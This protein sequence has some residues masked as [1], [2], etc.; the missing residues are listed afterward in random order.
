VNIV[1]A[2]S[3]GAEI[4]HG[5]DIAEFRREASSL[6]AFV[7]QKDAAF[8]IAHPEFKLTET[9]GSA[10]ESAIQ[11]RAAREPFQYI[12]GRQEFWGLE[13][14]VTPDVL[15]PR[16]ETEILVEAAIGILSQIKDAHVC[17]V[18]VGSGCIAVSIAHSLP[19]TTA[20]VTDISPAAI[21]VATRNAKR[22]DVDA[23]IDF[24]EADVFEGVTGSFDMI[25]SNPP[26]IPDE[27][28]EAL[29]TEVRD[30]EP[31]RALSGGRDG[32]DV[33]SRIV[34]EAP[35][36]LKPGGSLLMEIG[37]DQAARVKELF[38]KDLWPGL[39]FLPDLQGIPRIARAR[40]R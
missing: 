28:I 7:L 4:L 13:F 11:R 14:E 39:E 3:S 31:R 30:F 34:A 27:Q 22:H 20:V 10:F 32:T 33:I 9:Q 25:V 19:A 17:E 21:T 1:G 23:R 15:I 6:L 5:A 35:K 36:F 37:F 24:R 8:L 29:Q 16:P 38:E 18:G 40:Y 26:Y 2:L 12:T